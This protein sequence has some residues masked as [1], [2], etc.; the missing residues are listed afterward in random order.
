MSKPD[1]FVWER[2]DTE[3]PQCTYCLHLM[4]ED[5]LEMTCEAYPNGILK[6]ILENEEMHTHEIKGDKGVRF[7]L[8][9]KMKSEYIA[10]RKQIGKPL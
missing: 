3:L 6:K 8:D 9:P 1:K 4:N 5:I 2:D 7:E 10:F